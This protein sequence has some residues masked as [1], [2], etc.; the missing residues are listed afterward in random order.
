MKIVIA[1]AGEMGFHLA[2]LLAYEKQDITLLDNNQDVLENARGSLDVFTINGDAASV[3]LL[4]QAE[5]SKSDLFLAVTA[6][7]KT[8]LVAAILAKKLGAKQTVARVSNNEFLADDQR[9][10]FQELGVDSL[11]SPT[12]LAAK[13]IH[14]LIKRST[15]TDLFEFEDGRVSLLGIVF[16]DNSHLVNLSVSEIV[17]KIGD[18]GF[19]PIAILRGDSTII[20]RSS[21]IIKRADHAYF[22]ATRE[23]MD[24]L[25][26]E[27]GKAPVEVKNIMILGGGELG[28]RTAQ[29][30]ESEYRVTIVDNA[31]DTCKFLAEKLNNTLVVRGEPSNIE[32]LKEEGLG[33]MEGFIALTRNTET[34]I[35]TSLMAEQCGV[36]K[37]IALVDNAD[38]FHISQNIGVDTLIN[39]KL[40]AANNV[41]RFVR[42]GKIEAITS[43]HGVDA[44]VI[45]FVVHHESKL[46]RKKLRDLKFPKKAMIGAVVRE[47]VSLI[48]DGDFQLQLNDKVI[49]FSQNEDIAKVEELFR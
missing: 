44:E 2:R 23:S 35:I 13:E 41:F 37:T 36:F 8:N 5:V 30:L 39:K 6:S 48:P 11:I 20:P 28:Y 31:K 27:V 22:I 7:E 10:T 43:L 47:N 16:D 1:G 12:Q 18:V 17:E 26:N 19:K 40:I 32:L 42:R 29:L 25:L 9:K 38:Y 24:R 33:R 45:E 14:K 49:V 21:T 4:K 34:N 3:S 15:V 46:T